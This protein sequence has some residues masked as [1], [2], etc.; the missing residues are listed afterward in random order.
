MYRCVEK[1]DEPTNPFTNRSTY[2]RY[3]III[4]FDQFCS[5]IGTDPV[6]LD[7]QYYHPTN[8]ISNLN[9]LKNEAL[10]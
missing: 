7:I 9:V 10:K 3:S 8:L 5:W 4:E 1:T 6:Q 2:I